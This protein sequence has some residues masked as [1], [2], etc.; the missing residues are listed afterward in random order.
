MINMV[1]IRFHIFLEDETKT[2]SIQS[3]DSALNST[4]STLYP[5]IPAPHT[6]IQSTLSNTC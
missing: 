6:H 4:V 2:S 1:L 5:I 3:S